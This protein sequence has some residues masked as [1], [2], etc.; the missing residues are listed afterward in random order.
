M[1]AAHFVPI[2]G[3]AGVLVAT[4]AMAEESTA[5]AAATTAP[6]L[7]DAAR[8]K[9]VVAAFKGGQITVGDLEDNIA[10][11]NPFMQKRFMT[12]EARKGL[13]KKML[14]FDL[15]ALEAERRGY[16]D[17]ETVARS[18]KQNTVQAFIRTE[19][20]EKLSPESVTGEAIA[21]YYEE[22]I[23]EFMQPP[24]RRV[25][26]LVLA[27]RKE[28]ESRLENVRKLDLRNFR[29]LAREKSTDERT[30]LR[31][32]DLRFFDAKGDPR[33]KEQPH[34]ELPIV[35]AAFGMKEVGDTHSEVVQIEGGFSIVKLTGIRPPSE[36]TVAEADKTIRMRLWRV[37]RQKALDDFVAKLHAEHKPK[38][39]GRLVTLISFDEAQTGAKG[40]GLPSGFPE[41]RPHDGHT[42]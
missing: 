25:S 23:D 8:R 40:E 14:R 27:T 29:R 12:T 4:V 2:V 42:H 3:L 16:G 13:L 1:K 37:K 18:V 15:L 9:L 28:A 38:I 7:D 10:G 32:G 11:Q 35:K 36:R 30:K 24:M 20:D 34:V 17:N 33:S 41:N 19:F 39:D 21:A 6:A 5:P 31:G 26:H 22:H